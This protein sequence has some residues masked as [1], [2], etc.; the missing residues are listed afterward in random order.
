MLEEHPELAHDMTKLRISS[1]EQLSH[2]FG[3]SPE[4]IK[5][6]FE[7]FYEARQKVTLYDDVR[8]VLDVLKKSYQLVSLTNG[9]ASTEKTGVA[10]WFDFSLSSA[11]VGKLK[12]E[13]DIYLQVLERA[14]IEGYQMIHIGDHPLHDIAGAQS[15][16]VAAVWLN[17]ENRQW[18]RDECRPDAVVSSLHE[19]PALLSIL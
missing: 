14:G 4:W 17:R 10:H 5:P 19:V 15:A 2:E 1:F 3:L 9:N 16:G 13:P 18:T 12:S 8:P 11:T 6:A 7:I